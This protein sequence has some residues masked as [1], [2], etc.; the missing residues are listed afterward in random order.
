MAEKA[1]SPRTRARN[2][3]VTVDMHMSKAVQYCCHKPTWMGITQGRGGRLGIVV[4]MF[5]DGRWRFLVI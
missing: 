3:G 5:A 4:E 2:K 1:Y